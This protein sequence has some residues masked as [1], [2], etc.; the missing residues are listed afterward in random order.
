MGIVRASTPVPGLPR[1]RGLPGGPGCNTTPL[2]MSRCAAGGVDGAGQGRHTSSRPQGRQVTDG[3]WRDSTSRQGWQ[4]CHATTHSRLVSC[5]QAWEEGWGSWRQAH[6]N[7]Y[8]KTPQ[9]HHSQETTTPLPGL[10]LQGSEYSERPTT[11]RNH[12]PMR[13]LGLGS[14]LLVSLQPLTWAVTGPRLKMPQGEVRV[15]R[16]LQLLGNA[17]SVLVRNHAG[18]W[19]EQDF[20]GTLHA[21]HPHLSTCLLL[22]LCFL[23]RGPGWGGGW[24]G[25]QEHTG[26]CGMRTRDRSQA[27]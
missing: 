16:S 22:G 19:G 2:E 25:S 26:L 1:A 13:G 10:G 14:K 18:C 6:L 24:G 5:T 27:P 4:P 21:P 23:D 17:C 15:L 20:I 8:L 9:I 12:T 3:A 7:L 11:C